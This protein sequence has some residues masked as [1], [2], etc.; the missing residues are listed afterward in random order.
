M[1]AR[2]LAD[3]DSALAYAGDSARIGNLAR[4]GRGRA[5][6]ALGRFDAAASA[7]GAVP[8]S[9]A[10]RSE[11]SATVQQNQVF[12]GINATRRLSVADHQGGNGLDFRSAADP[13]VPTQLVGK[14]IDG[15]TDVYGFT[16]YNSVASAIVLASGTEARLI[17]AEAALRAGNAI[18]ALAILNELRATTPGLAPLALQATEGER[19][20]QLFRERAFWLFLSGH[21]Q[22][23]LRRLVRHYGRAQDAVFPAGPYRGG[24]LFGPEVT[25]TPTIQ[26]RENPNYK[27]CLDRAA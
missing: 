5:L 22:G 26:Q 7:V 25:F 4:V 20:D 9:Y 2:S 17:E 21:R 27:G 19:V 14:G 24:Q 10:Y 8:T 16:R 23:D 3:F 11:H 6:L 1:L 12:N 13:R 18:D 15:A